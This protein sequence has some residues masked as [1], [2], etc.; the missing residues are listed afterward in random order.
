MKV[1]II[2]FLGFLIGFFITII[3][4][5]YITVENKKKIIEKYETSGTTTT[6][7]PIPTTIQ[8]SENKFMAINSFTDKIKIEEDSGNLNF[9]NL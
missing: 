6:I 9:G 2:K 8:S 5:N 7:V 1:F 4:I 3:L